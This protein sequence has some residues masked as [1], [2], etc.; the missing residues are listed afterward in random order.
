MNKDFRRENNQLKDYVKQT[1]RFEGTWNK[2]CINK[3]TRNIFYK[4]KRVEEK[5]KKIHLCSGT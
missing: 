3:K 1:I 2:K 5:K 4:S